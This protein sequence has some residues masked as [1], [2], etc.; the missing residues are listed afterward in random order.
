MESADAAGLVAAGTGD[1]VQPP[2]ET[3]ERADV[4][5]LHADRRPPA[6][7]RRRHRSRGTRALAAPS[8]C[9]RPNSGC[10]S[11]ASNPT[12][13][14][15]TAPWREIFP[16]SVPCRDRIRAR[17]LGSSSHAL[18]SRL[19]LSSARMRS[20]S[21]W[22]SSGASSK[23][24][25]RRVIAKHLQQIVGAE[26]AHRRFR[27]MRDLQI[28][29]D[30]IDVLRVDQIERA[31]LCQKFLRKLIA[32]QRQ[33]AGSEP[34]PRDLG[35]GERRASLTAAF[36]LHHDVE[37][38]R[39]P[40]RNR[41]LATVA[42]RSASGDRSAGSRRSLPGDIGAVHAV[43]DA[44]QHEARVGGISSARSNS[45]KSKFSP[46]PMASLGRLALCF[47]TYRSNSASIAWRTGAIEGKANSWPLVSGISADRSGCSRRPRPNLPA[48]ELAQRQR[49]R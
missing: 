12:G 44:R 23:R 26:I 43:D 7:A 30:A 40:R 36:G 48:V 6:S 8:P 1:V 41:V 25:R 10:N 47:A 32:G 21:I 29:F 45:W 34:S 22:F 33:I 9:I 20:R 17:C 27:R 3:A 14:G 11:D 46:T 38:H 39:Q 13:V 5:Q 18:K 37:R 15:A 24:L 4:L 31:V 35:A 16:G 2:L 42:R 19:S 49:D 28:G